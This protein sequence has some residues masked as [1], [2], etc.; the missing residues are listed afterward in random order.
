MDA[1]TDF[2]HADIGSGNE[3]G[4]LCSGSEHLWTSPDDAQVMT[5][6]TFFSLFCGGAGEMNDELMEPASG[7]K[8]SMET[9]PEE[10]HHWTIYHLDWATSAVDSMQF[11]LSGFGR[12]PAGPAVSLQA[13]SYGRNKT[14]A[15]AMAAF[16]WDRLDEHVH[17]ASQFAT[18]LVTMAD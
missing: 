7:T 14:A 13:Q 12:G 4:P 2:D 9:T 17:D 18:E 1:G 16:L 10:P 6:R 3:A 11:R 15:A 8:A 5:E